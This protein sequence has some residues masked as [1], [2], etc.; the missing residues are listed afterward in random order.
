MN[1]MDGEDLGRLRRVILRWPLLLG[2]VFAGAVLAARLLDGGSP[3]VEGP[4]VVF[5]LLGA[6]CLAAWKLGPEN[7]R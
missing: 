6:S 3:G 7:G 1:E 5:L 2:T 4:L